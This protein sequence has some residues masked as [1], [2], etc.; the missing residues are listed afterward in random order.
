[1]SYFSDWVKI[2]SKDFWKFILWVLNYKQLNLNR[3]HS[4]IIYI[5]GFILT[6]KCT[7]VRPR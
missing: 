7:N 1:M 4:S 2:F 5:H 6:V 3:M